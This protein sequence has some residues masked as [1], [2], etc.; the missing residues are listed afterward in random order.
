M[1]RIPEYFR[2]PAKSARTGIPSANRSGEIISSAVKGLADTFFQGVLA[3]ET[4]SKRLMDDATRAKAIGEYTT[5]YMQLS[6]QIKQENLE[7]PE[8]ATRQLREL[9]AELKNKHVDNLTD[10]GLQQEFAFSVDNINVQEDIRDT[11]WKIEQNTLISQK[12]YTDRISSDA[13]TAATLPAYEDYLTLVGRFQ[14]EESNA[15][16][17]R[18]LSQAFGGLEQGQKVLEQGLESITRG[19][20]SG[21]MARGEGFEAAQHLIRGD[22]D[23]FIS[24]QVKAELTAK[25][26][27]AQA[28]ETRKS[29][30]IQAAEAAVDVFQTAGDVLGRNLDIVGLEEKISQVSF[31]IATAEQT[32]KSPEQIKTL[33]GHLQLLERMRDLELEQIEKTSKDDIETKA[34]LLA[35]YQFLVD[36][37][38]G[39]NSLMGTLDEVLKFQRDLTEAFYGGKLSKTTYQKWMLFT[40]TAIQND[41]VEA[42]AERGQGFQAPGGGLFGGSSLSSSRK[43]RNRLADILKNTNKGLGREHAVDTLEFYMDLVND[44]LGGNIDDIDQITDQTHDTLVKQAK[45]RATLKKMGLPVYLTVGNRVPVNGGVYEIVDIANDGMPVI[46]VRDE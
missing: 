14:A 32:R 39:Q 4:K 35:D 38:D 44:Q 33:E 5:E 21:K 45:A 17:E 20:I 3:L 26:N 15:E 18:R 28:G 6:N 29:N 13:R 10:Q 40:E 37:E 19:F 2:G 36:Y 8:D 12:K 43:I 22:F 9:R 23:L 1:G 34:D 41:I 7:N 11:A 31:A 16:G 42:M 25:L 46:K 24:P 27:Q 30:F